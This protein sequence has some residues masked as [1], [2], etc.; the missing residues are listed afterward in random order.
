VQVLAD[1]HN[2]Q[3]GTVQLIGVQLEPISIY[4]GMHFWH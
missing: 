1:R 4:V 3:F 2:R